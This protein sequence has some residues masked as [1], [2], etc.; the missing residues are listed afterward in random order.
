MAAAGLRVSAR[1]VPLAVLLLDAQYLYIVQTVLLFEP[2]HST[3]L[4]LFQP[5][6]P[7]DR[8]TFL[9][10]LDVRRAVSVPPAALCQ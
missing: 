2:G 10:P 9:C 1:A 4:S 7:G 3:A 6:S 5:L 8:S